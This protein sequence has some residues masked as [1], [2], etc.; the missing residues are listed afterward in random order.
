MGTILQIN[1]EKYKFFFQVRISISLKG[2]ILMPSLDKLIISNIFTNKA[3][4]SIHV[5]THD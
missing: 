3:M 1:N 5:S 4:A 2:G